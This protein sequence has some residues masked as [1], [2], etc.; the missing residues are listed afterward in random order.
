MHHLLSVSLL[1]RIA[2]SAGFAVATPHKAW[3]LAPT[4]YILWLPVIDL[5][6]TV[7]ATPLSP[8]G[9]VDS[10]TSPLTQVWIL[11]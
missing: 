7:G 3:Q 1:Y 8:E 2:H 4:I 11:L 9:G 10:T 5:G 6:E